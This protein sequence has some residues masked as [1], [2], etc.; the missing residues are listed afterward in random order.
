[1]SISVNTSRSST[2][3]LHREV[4]GVVEEVAHFLAKHIFM[5]HL[6]RIIHPLQYTFHSLSHSFTSVQFYKAFPVR[7]LKLSRIQFLT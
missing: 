6:F 7:Q 4:G 3:A 5:G 2:T 1:M